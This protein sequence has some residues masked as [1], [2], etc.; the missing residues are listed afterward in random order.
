MGKILCFG[1]LFVEVSIAQTSL[2]M[3]FHG[4]KNDHP[5]SVSGGIYS[6]CWGYTAPD[7]REYAILGCYNGTAIIEITDSPTLVERAFIPGPPSVWH[8]MKTYRNIAY[9]V[10]EASNVLQGAGIQILDI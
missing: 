1:L 9:I 6:A 5:A 10:S 8:E 3:E 2:N 4:N 7:G